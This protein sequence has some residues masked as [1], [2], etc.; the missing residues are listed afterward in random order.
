[1]AQ[2]LVP[3]ASIPTPRDGWISAIREALGMS[4]RDMARRM[5]IAP[6]SASRIEQREREGAI[7]LAA[8]RKA[9]AALD[10]ELVYA[11]VP[12]R[13]F[14]DSSDTENLLDAMIMK[15]ARDAAAEDLER[16]G[17]TM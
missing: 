4:V 1:M 17:K 10:C 16:V 7:T 3:A 2:Y 6:S 12:R 11:V 14:L 9:A 15:H 13:E 8:L 5:A